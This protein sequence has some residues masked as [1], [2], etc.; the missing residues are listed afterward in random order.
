MILKALL[1][2]S[3]ESFY[4]FEA[5]LSPLKLFADCHDWQ[6]KDDCATFNP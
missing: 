1:Q 3:N 5:G 6:T 2:S 4:V